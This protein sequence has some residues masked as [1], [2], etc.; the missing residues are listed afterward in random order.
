MNQTNVFQSEGISMNEVEE[1]LKELYQRESDLG[2]K[3]VAQKHLPTKRVMLE[4]KGKLYEEIQ[5]L[6][7][8]REDQRNKEAL[9][10]IDKLIKDNIESMY[11]SINGARIPA[12]ETIELQFEPCHHKKKMPLREI[13]RRYEFRE[14]HNFPEPH[15]YLLQ[16]WQGIFTRGDIFQPVFSCSQCR[17]EQDDL[18]AK[19]HIRRGNAVIGHCRVIVR[20]LQ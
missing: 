9:P 3:I 8:K 11:I 13:I 2:S 4:E 1:K 5:A 7:R 14:E 20:T 17:Q 19:M 18:L 15:T 12:T 16:R 10:C 6:E